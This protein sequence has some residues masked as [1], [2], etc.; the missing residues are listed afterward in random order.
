MDTWSLL[1]CIEVL[2]LYAMIADFKL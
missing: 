1:C 2:L